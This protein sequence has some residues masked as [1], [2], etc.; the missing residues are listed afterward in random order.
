MEQ[1]TMCA[2][3]VSP[4]WIL[5]WRWWIHLLQINEWISSRKWHIIWMSFLN[6]ILKVSSVLACDIKSRDL[7]E[8]LEEKEVPWRKK[9]IVRAK[10]LTWLLQSFFLKWCYYLFPSLRNYAYSRQIFRKV[11]HSGSIWLSFLHE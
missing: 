4:Y 2:L 6:V 3:Y 10:E 9:R 1:L 11:F 7:G 5:H 8:I